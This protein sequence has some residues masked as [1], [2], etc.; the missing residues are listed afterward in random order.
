MGNEW[1]NPNRPG[2]NFV[3]AYQASGIPYVT[4]SNGDEIGT[5]SKVI[6]FPSVTR[7]FQV[8]NTSA[9]P[10]R[11]GFTK[12]GVEGTGAIS[13]STVGK[14]NDPVHK[15]YFVISG[16]GGNTPTSL[17]LELRCKE[18]WLRRDAGTNTGFSLIAGLTSILPSDFPTLSGSTGFRGVG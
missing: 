4:S 17:R 2:P 7:F 3:P 6:K 9:H 8:T 1:K 10:L 16:S 11:I 13:G 12:S 18:L 5:V 14:E 15:N